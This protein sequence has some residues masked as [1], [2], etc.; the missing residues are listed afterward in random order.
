MHV[1]KVEEDFKCQKLSVDN[2]IEV[3][4]KETETATITIEDC[5]DVEDELEESASEKYLGDV[6]SKDCRNM[7]NIKARVAKGTGITNRGLTY[8]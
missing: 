2:W 3:P 5:F 4:V 7:K 6:I 8:F 1:G